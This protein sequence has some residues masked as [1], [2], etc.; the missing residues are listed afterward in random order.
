MF[1]LALYQSHILDSFSAPYIGWEWWSRKDSCGSI[2][3]WHDYLV[4]RVLGERSP[5]VGRFME[6]GN[7]A[8]V[9]SQLSGYALSIDETVQGFCWLALELGTNCP[10]E[11][12]LWLK[13]DGRECWVIY[14]DQY[15]PPTIERALERQSDSSQKTPPSNAQLDLLCGA[16]YFNLVSVA[17]D[18]LQQSHGLRYV[19]VDSVNYCAF[20]L[21]TIVQLTVA[22]FSHR[23]FGLPPSVDMFSC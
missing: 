10:G 5:D 19:Q 4:F 1:M 17:E 13:G 14:P 16:A 9:L 21:T 6:I 3:L 12:Q 8:K 2:K 18:L 22:A 11:R 20:F 7:A 15:N 23:Q